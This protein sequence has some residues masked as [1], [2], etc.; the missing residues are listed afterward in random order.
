MKRTLL[1]AVMLAGLA[2]VGTF[3]TSIREMLLIE[4]CMKSNWRVVALR[5]AL[6]SE[7]P[8]LVTLVWF[9]SKPRTET[10]SGITSEYSIVMPGRFFMNSATLPSITSP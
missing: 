2:G 1:L 7:A 3:V 8:S 6:A 9:G 5:E 4:T 10:A